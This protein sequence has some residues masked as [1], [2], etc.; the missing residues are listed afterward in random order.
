ME[1]Y[2]ERKKDLHMVS[3][4]L[5][6]TY[7]KLL[8]E[9]L[10]RCLEARGVPVAYF[11]LIKDTYDGVKT[12]DE[13]GWWG[14]RPFSGYDGVASGVGTQPFFV[15]YVDGRTNSPHPR[16]GVV[17]MLFANDILLIDEMRDGVNAQLEVW[18]QTLESKGFKLSRT[19]TEYL[20]YKFSGET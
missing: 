17:V 14:L 12:R 10:W 15:C 18:R 2:R 16:G 13:D 3:I 7:D 8:R 9:V 19:K 1:Q 5:E 11:R 6:K 4:D 20:E